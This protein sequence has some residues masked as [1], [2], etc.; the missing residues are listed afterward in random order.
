MPGIMWRVF[1]LS[2]DIGGVGEL[3]FFFISSIITETCI[4]VSSGDIAI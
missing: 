2:G 3:Q 4:P 1:V